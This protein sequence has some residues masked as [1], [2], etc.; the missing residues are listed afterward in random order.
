MTR[1]TQLNR[2]DISEIGAIGAA[3]NLLVVDGDVSAVASN[4]YQTIMP[5]DDAEAALDSLDNHLAA[6]G[7]P[8]MLRHDR[9]TLL[10]IQRLLGDNPGFQAS[11]KK[12]YEDNPPPEPV[13]EPEPEEVTSKSKSR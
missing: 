12:W 9:T 13:A 4:A 6:Q 10:A 5:G 7:Y 2:I 11:A 1:K 3:F 8:K